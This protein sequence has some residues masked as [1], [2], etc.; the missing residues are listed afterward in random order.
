MTLLSGHSFDVWIAWVIDFLDNSAKRALRR[1]C[2]ASRDSVHAWCMHP[3]HTRYETGF[4]RALKQ[5]ELCRRM[6]A[7]KTDIADAFYMMTLSGRDSPKMSPIISGILRDASLRGG[8]SALPG[9][10]RAEMDTR[11]R[12]E[13]EDVVRNFHLWMIKGK[14]TLNFASGRAEFLFHMHSTILP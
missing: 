8:P 13:R 1:T 14:S 5:Y 6:S 4:L 11:A 7:D 12:L 2:S 9:L 10:I 3:T